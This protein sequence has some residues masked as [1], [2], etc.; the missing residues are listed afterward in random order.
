MSIR[1][2]AA[3]A[4][5]LATAGAVIV[6][7]A[8]CAAYGI[9]SGRWWTWLLLPVAT[10]FA[11][12]LAFVNASYNLYK[13]EVKVATYSAIAAATAVISAGFARYVA[14]D[15]V[16]YAHARLQSVHLYPWQEQASSQKAQAHDVLNFTGIGGHIGF[17]VLLVAAVI[18]TLVVGACLINIRRR[19][20]HLRALRRKTASAV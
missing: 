2:V 20:A 19:R 5:L 1:R 15:N 17:W 3:L 18:L 6:I 4:A 8:Q 11:V 12:W 10:I 9:E 13:P 16:D 14:K 7:I